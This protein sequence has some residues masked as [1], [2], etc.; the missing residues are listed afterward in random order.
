MVLTV[1]PNTGLDHVLFLDRLE[2]GRRNAARG[3]WA[4]GGKGCDVSLILR[5]LEVATVA[6]GF[7]AGEIGHRMESML[8]AVGVECRFVPTG[9]ETRVNTVLIEA[10]TGTHTTI[11]AEGLRV[12][13]A[14]ETALVAAVEREAERARLAVLA[15]SLPE[16]VALELYPRLIAVLRRAGVP[17][18]LDTAEPYLGPALAAGVAAV[19]PNRAELARWAGEAVPDAAAAA[20]AARRMREAGAGTVLASLDR[21]GMLLVTADGAWYAPPLAIPVQNPAGAGDG[22]VAGLCHALLRGASP[23]EQLESALRVASAVCLTPGTA[24]F[25]RED[26]ASLPPVRLERLE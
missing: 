2:P 24:E 6:T 3:V 11:C 16:R 26:L 19:K 14:H 8:A 21:E 9:G 25:H 13:P 18:V 10:A 12:E 20:R 22:A 17:V 5:G 15:G 4:M 23:P 1:T 7:A